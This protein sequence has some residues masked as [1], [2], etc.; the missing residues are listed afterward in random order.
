[1]PKRDG[2]SRWRVEG[3][4]L[5]KRSEMGG[6]SGGFGHGRREMEGLIRKEEREWR[7]SVWQ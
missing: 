3:V 6:S 7:E 4:V 1:V 5:S 2:G